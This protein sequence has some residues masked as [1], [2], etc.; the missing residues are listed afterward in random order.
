MNKDIKQKVLSGFLGTE[1]NEYYKLIYSEYEDYFY[2]SK[3]VNEL[4]NYLLEKV[5]VKREDVRK[6]IGCLLLI[7]II[8][9]FQSSVLLLQKGLLDQAKM[10]IRCMIEAF[11]IFK[12]N[13][14][15]EEFF[16]KYI[17]SYEHDRLGLGKSALKYGIGNSN[18]IKSK[19][20]EV[21]KLIKDEDIQRLFSS[22]V[23]NKDV[24]EMPY[25][26]FS[27][28][29]HPTIMNLQENYLDNETS[30]NLEIICGP[31]YK[32]LGGI[33]LINICFLLDTINISNNFFNFESNE[34][35]KKIINRKMNRIDKYFRNIKK[36]N[37]SL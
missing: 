18:C 12:R 16:K 9:S 22:D 17:N 34:Q 21:N 8:E 29:I 15:D 6:I 27:E 37:N 32:G 30:K 5:D 11:A 2:L 23:I 14:E 35:T 36:R 24:F 19:I 25:R 33:L 31:K 1:Y 4:S 3:R 13:V 7:K 20:E 10:I 28:S 26:L